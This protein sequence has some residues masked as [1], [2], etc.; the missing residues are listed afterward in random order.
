MSADSTVC[1][2]KTRNNNGTSVEYRV[3]VI[4][5]IENLYSTNVKRR[6]AMLVL[7]FGESTIPALTSLAEAQFLANDLNSKLNRSPIGCEYGIQILDFTDRPYPNYTKED[8]L[9]IIGW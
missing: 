4:H 5:A 1:I 7:C 3:S 9:N 8:A 6:D 2:L